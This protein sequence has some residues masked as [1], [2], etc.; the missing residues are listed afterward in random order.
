MKLK[1]RT[2]LR[3]PILLLTILLALFLLSTLIPYQPG[4][5]S[6]RSLVST[7]IIDRH[8]IVLRDILSSAMGTARYAPIQKIPEAVKNAFIAAE[9]KRF[10]RHHG[11]DGLAILRAIREFI[12]NRRIVSGA[13]TITQQLIRMIHAHPRNLFIKFYENWLALRLEHALNKDEILEQY[14]NRVPLGNMTFGV[15]SASQLYFAKSVS[16]LTVAEAALLAAIPKSPTAYNPFIFFD[17]VLERQKKILQLMVRNRSLSE[18]Q[19]DR[20]KSQPINLVNAERVFRA[21]HFCNYIISH[22]VE[23]QTRPTEIHTTLDWHLQ[24]NIQYYVNGRLSEL[25]SFHVHNAVVLVMENK[26][27]EIRVW[28]GSNNFFDAENAGQVDGILSLRQPG[29]TLKPFTYGLALK[30]GMTAASIIPDIETHAREVSGYFTP[31]NYDEKYHGPVTLRRALA[32]SYNIPPIRIAEQLGGTAVLQTLH[33]AGFLSLNKSPNHYGLGLTLGNG[34]VT[35]LELVCAYAALAN[36]GNVLRS[37][38]VNSLRFPGDDDQL[39]LRTDT[40]GTLF[41]EN[42]NFM[43]MDILSDDEARVPAFG[44]NNPLNLP[45]DCAAK[46]GTSKDYRDNWAIGCTPELTVGVWVGNF[47]GESMH[48]IS[49]ISGSGPLLN[50]IMYFLDKYYQ[51]TPFLE[52]AELE[53]TEICQLSGKR[54]TRFC[55]DTIIEYFLPGTAPKDSC[56]WHRSIP[57]DVRTGQRASKSTNPQFIRHQIFMDLPPLYLSWM[58]ENH[59]P[60]I[61]KDSTALQSP[62]R[63][64]ELRITSPKEGDIYKMDSILR[65]GYQRI[66][67]EAEVPEQIR[68]IEWMINGESFQTVDHPFHVSWQLQPGEYEFRVCAESV[69]SNTVKILVLP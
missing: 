20:I 33:R 8:G 27:G 11:I 15:E 67:L 16:Q 49:G 36:G 2:Y 3:Q 14:L 10:Y 48:Q 62:E 52:P 28:I 63:T 5:L 47:S 22:Y 64:I 61:P 17:R 50:D 39:F 38:Y 54:K 57:I 23:N 65:P 46:T 13:S 21:P 42:I 69:K 30:N 56:T 45:F 34:E 51:F 43:L 19:M 53:T 9:D 32:C 35:L 58:L 6:T 1:I 26:T 31:K 41:D 29:S 4:T 55:T 44:R 25:K 12:R 37:Q 24:E 40:L 18:D 7:Q 60:L 68:R 66:A 59:L